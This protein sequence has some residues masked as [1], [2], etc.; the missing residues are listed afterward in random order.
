[1]TLEYDIESD[2]HW[3]DEPIVQLFCRDSDGNRRRVDVEGFYPFFYISEEELKEH[4]D[5]IFSESMIR[6][7]E[8]R[9]ES[10]SVDN[11]HNDA[12][13]AAST[14]PRETLHGEPLVKITTVK[15]NHVSDLRDYFDETWE[16]D[17]FFTNRFLIESEITR[18]LE[19]PT[20]A[21]RV[22]FDDIE[23]CEPPE[24]KPRLLCVDIEVYTGGTFPSPEKAEM[25]V[26]AVTAYDSYD[27][28]YI[29]YAL[30]PSTVVDDSS[31]DITE[32]SWEE[33]IEEPDWPVPEGVDP[34]SVEMEVFDREDYLLGALNE[35][36]SEKDGALLSGWN[37]SAN[38][39]GSGFDYPYIINR[40]KNIG[41]GTYEKLSNTGTCFVSGRGSAV[42]GG[43]ELFDMLQAYE[44]TQIHEKESY[45]L[46]AIAED[47]LGYGKEEV[48]GGLDH[49]WLHE[50]DDFI[51]YNIRDV[52][53]VIEI[54]EVK[55][56][57]DMYDHIRSIAGATYSE[58]ADSNIGIID[59]L[60]LREAKKRGLAL[61]TS[62]KPEKG[63]YYGGEV[64]EPVPGKHRKVVYPD[65]KSL[66]PYGMW[67]LNVSPE[68]LY[69]SLEEARADGYEESQL[70]SAYIDYR[71]EDVKKDNEP[72]LTEI[73]YVK[74][75]YKEGFVRS[76]I[77]E[78][79]DM[80]YEYK[81]DG[82]P[83]EAYAAVKRIVNS[84][85]TPDTE[86]LTPDGIRNITD[87][88]EGDD[89]YSW[90]PETGQMEV[91]PVVET[92]EKP[93]YRG[94]LVQIQNENMD[95]KV[96]P[97]H[98]LYT[99]RPRYDS[100][101]EI[102]EAGE[103]NEWTHYET[104]NRWE[105]DHANGIE[106]IDIANYINKD[107]ELTEYTI[108]AGK[109]HSTFDRFIDGDV[110]IDLIGW[111]ITEGSAYISG[112]GGSR[113]DSLHFAQYQSVNPDEYEEICS[114]C[115]AL[116]CHYTKCDESI[117]ISGSVYTEFLTNLCGE[118]SEEKYI[119]EVV[120]ERASDEQK[121][122][123]LD[124][125]MMGDG[126]SRETPNRYT[127]KS[128]QLRDDF[129]RLLWEL[130]HKPSYKWEESNCRERRGVW[131]IHYTC[132]ERGDEA[133]QSFRMH[134][135]G[136]TETAENGVYCVQ[137]EDNHTL[138]AGRNGK[139]VNILNC[140]GTFGDSSSYGKG[141]R[142]F[143]WRLAES[144]TI[145]GREVL[146]YTAEEFTKYLQEEE[147]SDSELIGGDSVPANEPILVD[148]GNGTEIISI[149]DVVVGDSV[150]SNGGWTDVENV[151]KKENK[152]Q[153]YTVRTKGGV[154]HVTEDHSLVTKDMKEISPEEAM[155]GDS[156]LHEDIA[157]VSTEGL[158]FDEKR[159]WL[160]GLFA[161]EGSCGIYNSE[162]GSKASWAI[163]NSERSVLEEAKEIMSEV[164]GIRTKIDNVMESSGTMKL[165]LH[166][167]TDNVS[168]VL[169]FREMLYEGTEKRVP[170]EILQSPNSVKKSFLSGYHTGGGHIARDSKEFDEMWT[171]H[172]HLG[173]G[174]A[175]LLRQTGHKIT[176]S[177]RQ[178]ESFEYYRIR[179][180][181]FH[182]GSNEEIREIEE[183]DYDGDYVYDLE[184]E[185]HHFQSG[186]GSIIVHNT[187]SCMT[188]ISGAENREEA[189]GAAFRAAEYVND[190][191]DEF[192][193]RKFNIN[194]PDMHKTEVEVESYADSLF[195]Q[196]NFKDRERNSG[197]K[198]R[199]AQL[200]TW[201]E[202][203]YI[204]DPEVD[205]KGFELVR[206]D[207]SA[208]TSRV[209]EG[210]LERILRE[211]NPEESVAEYVKEE[212]NSVLDGDVDLEALGKPSA[213]NK[214]LWDYGWS[215]DE[216]SGEVNYY[217]PQ[218]RIRGARYSNEY[219]SGENI[220]EGSKPL[221]FY[222]K[223]IVPNTDGL[224]ETY[225]YSHKNLNAPE[226]GGNTK[227]IKELDRDVDAI[228]VED[229]DNIP[230]VARIDWEKLAEKNVRNPVEPITWT[231]GWDFDELVSDGNQQSLVQFM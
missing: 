80:K 123:L 24:V 204:E 116:G 167:N 103:L 29:V 81:S 173:A 127:T 220:Q 141:F 44:K 82:H 131:R 221:F 68:T 164:F 203:E 112:P 56:I 184:T 144:I 230:E 9:T 174:I 176:T 33:T 147:Y 25:P 190:S 12:F 20:G 210:V 200:I 101:W 182:R 96:T 223:D 212:W 10:V 154:T 84:C 191:Y 205:T 7:V 215:E 89:V 150:W 146:N 90:N 163:N 102:A 71:D 185:N 35:W 69:E 46:D 175:F 5:T 55:G 197:T 87:I 79:T 104:P 207:S 129:V 85:F 186:I 83:D 171:K 148:R 178:E 158:F 109:T 76:V 138:V 115:D 177:I 156:L 73:Y 36:I 16:A 1:M 231:M 28:E 42:V 108:T 52:E 134:R 110:F 193:S 111:Y 162:W 70:Y 209:Q 67:S 57:I 49:G 6:S 19:V 130:G 219:I 159:A 132:D 198:K 107:F 169:G 38:N 229:I 2:G 3:L 187:D 157:S 135:D 121:Q 43:R 11:R 50:P 17:I 213:I 202:G 92:I 161:A 106:S 78:L 199:Y 15:P 4:E 94:E 117:Q 99:K 47:E 39:K 32:H 31:F 192:V 65:L 30:H 122:R 61:P 72:E 170:K 165:R 133:K 225:D 62:T 13:K 53:A 172:K 91:K 227:R 114:M 34:D 196:A 54:E 40:C 23:S 149:E 145:F 224:P 77:T 27:E 136:S 153:L 137:V 119:P 86:V 214:D 228:A 226:S 128:D 64:I 151:I 206:S 125:L 180:V 66:Y 48:E 41:E 222:V 195:F 208:L 51:K 21:Q 218:P 142:L 211:E 26:T 37:S 188:E 97:D 8:A 105:Y 124:V 140:Y 118:G 166:Y 217:T 45:A 59:I 22:H 168:T 120:F 100:G 14:A 98:R 216:D 194:D 201:D 139:F 179:A 93:E 183:Y 143:D 189:L 58:C 95:I 152:K 160:L 18:G 88:E 63:W 75:E 74:P 113:G 126:D 155:V 60:Y 181:K